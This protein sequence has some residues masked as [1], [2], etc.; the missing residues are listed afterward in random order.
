MFVILIKDMAKSMFVVLALLTLAALGSA[1]WVPTEHAY[2]PDVSGQI[3]GAIK[4]K[5]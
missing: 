5:L 2:S 4:Q 3:A 1:R